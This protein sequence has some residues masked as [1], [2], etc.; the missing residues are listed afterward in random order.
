MADFLSQFL[1]RTQQPIQDERPLNDQAI[2]QTANILEQPPQ[3]VAGFVP[4]PELEVREQLAGQLMQTANDRSVHPLARGLSAY[5][6]SKQLKDLSS[7]RAKTE[8]GLQ[9]IERRR[10]QQALEES[11]AFDLQKQTMGIDAQKALQAERLASQ[12]AGQRERLAFEREQSALDRATADRAAQI[13]AMQTAQGNQT[14]A[15]ELDLKRRKLEAEVTAKEQKVEEAET[16]KREGVINSVD[17]IDNALAQLDRMMA[18]KD[19]FTGAVGT[20]FTKFLTPGAGDVEKEGGGFLA[21]TDEA[22]FAEDLKGVK[23]GAFM[24]GREALKGSGTI[25]DFESTKAERALANLSLNQ[26]E[27]K[28]EENVNAYRNVLLRGRERAI[29]NAEKLGIEIPTSQTTPATSAAAP[30]SN[31]IQAEL[32]RR[33]LLK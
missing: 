21:G 24:Q 17:S 28:F 6:G 22:N 19:G 31:D 29:K 13:R 4:L 20:G 27:E 26:S 10:Q 23:G 30:S 5:F 32:R 25:T 18:N 16:A 3:Q 15:E 14:R 11:R 1:N 7:E 9:D 2:E 33:G 8:R 12:R